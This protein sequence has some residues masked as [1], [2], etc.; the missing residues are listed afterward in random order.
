MESVGMLITEMRIHTRSLKG[1]RLH[2]T[3]LTSSLRSEITVSTPDVLYGALGR[4]ALPD[5]PPAAA[6]S[7]LLPAPAASAGVKAQTYCLTQ[8]PA[9]LP[10]L[11]NSNRHAALVTFCFTPLDAEAASSF[12]P[13]V[14]V[15]CCFLFHANDDV[16]FPVCQCP[17]PANKVARGCFQ[18]IQGTPSCTHKRKPLADAV[19]SLQ[20]K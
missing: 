2:L 18:A 14:F 8:G 16:C 9:A 3:S 1:S 11:I 5:W 4:G 10:P 12:F 19:G 15:L 13:D 7:P 20:I 6:A 17:H